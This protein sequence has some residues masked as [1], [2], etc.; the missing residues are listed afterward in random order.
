M[1]ERLTDEGMN[2][3]AKEGSASAMLV[4]W[5]EACRARES[6]KELLEALKETRARAA[7][8]KALETAQAQVAQ[9]RSILNTIVNERWWIPLN[10]RDELDEGRRVLEA[11]GPK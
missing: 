9:L 7:M 1:S 4:L 10:N 11:T 5:N 6:E 3:L 8:G 2:R